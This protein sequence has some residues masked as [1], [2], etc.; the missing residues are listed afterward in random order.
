VVYSIIPV[1]GL[2]IILYAA[3]NLFCG[4]PPSHK[5]DTD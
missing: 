1:S 4:A 3:I 2:L 5:I